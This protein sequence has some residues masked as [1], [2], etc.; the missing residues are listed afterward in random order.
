MI[1]W[2]EAVLPYE[3]EQYLCGGVVTSADGEGTLEWES[4]KKL[5]VVGSYDSTFFIKSN[6]HP[7]QEKQTHMFVSGNPSKFLQGHNIFGSDDLCYLLIWAVKKALITV[8]C[9]VDLFTWNRWYKG[10]FELKRVDIAQMFTVDN[11]NDVRSFIRALSH[12]GRMRNRGRGEFRG[13]TLYF[14]K[15]SKRWAIKVYSKGDE[16]EKGGKKHQ[17]PISMLNAHPGIEQKLKA[18][19]DG[20]IRI[21]LVLRSL[22]LARLGLSNGRYWPNLWVKQLWQSH[23]DKVEM[24]DQS[25]LSDE[26]AATLPKALSRTYFMWKDGQDIRQR[27]SKASFY[28]HRAE[29][30]QY[31]I[32][33]A[34]L[35]NSDTDNVVP[36]VRRIEAKPMPVPNWAHDTEFFHESPREKSKRIS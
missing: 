3:H 10:D 24:T 2:I 8:N 35:Q 23:W 32:D 27:M 29:L 31:G 20:A 34:E 11:R 22:E 16:I 25:I 1:D 28:R 15:H 4:Y 33:I 6:G 14:G 19:Y 5:P 30:K 12:T 26:A 18:S 36:F 13:D 21:E 7:Q 17:L 9:G